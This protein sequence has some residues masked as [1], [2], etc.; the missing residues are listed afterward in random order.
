[1]LLVAIS[2]SLLLSIFIGKQAIAIFLII[3]GIWLAFLGSKENSKSKVFWG[4]I[5]VSISI[6]YAIFLNIKIKWQI[7]VVIF[8][9]GII[10]TLLIIN[11]M[12]MEKIKK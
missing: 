11:S 2:I 9:G 7:L 1:M 8:I 5:L 6:S 10:A 3:L 12:K 4:G